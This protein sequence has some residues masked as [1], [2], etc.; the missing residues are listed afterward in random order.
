MCHMD[1]ESGKFSHL[2]YIVNVSRMYQHCLVIIGGMVT[3]ADLSLLGMLDFG[4]DIGF[5]GVV[6]MLCHFGLL[7]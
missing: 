6:S 1:L 2:G 5:R 7:H 4:C 3:R